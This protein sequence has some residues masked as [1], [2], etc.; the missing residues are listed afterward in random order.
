MPLPSKHGIIRLINRVRVEM[1]DALDRRC[2]AP[3]DHDDRARRPAVR[4][5][6]H[7]AA[8]PHGVLGLPRAGAPPIPA[9]AMACTRK[10]AVPPTGVRTTVWQRGAGR[11]WRRRRHQGRRRDDL[12]RRL[13]QVGLLRFDGLQQVLQ[14]RKCFKHRG[15]HHYLYLPRHLGGS[16]GVRSNQV[17]TCH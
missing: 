13:A 8:R 17:G 1:I 10:R 15:L 12:A 9:A 5:Q 7:A 4:A 11:T 14:P 6:P 16:V 2:G 3:P